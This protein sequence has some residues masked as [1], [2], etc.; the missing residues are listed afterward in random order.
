[1]LTSVTLTQN[2]LT[3]IADYV[4]V[5]PLKLLDWVSKT[6]PQKT[7]QF[8]LSQNPAAICFILD[9]SRRIQLEL[10]TNK[11]PAAIHIWTNL[12]PDLLNWHYL[13]KSQ[14]DIDLLEKNPN[15]IE[16]K[17]LSLNPAA[18]HLL[19]S[20]SDRINWDN[21]S[22]N[23]AAIHLLEA[24]PDC[25]NWANLSKN[26]A[27]IH[28]IEA[29]LDRINWDNLSKNTAAIHLLE[30]NPDCI[31]WD[32]LSKNP[33]AVHL[34]EANLDCINWNNL[35]QNP[36]AIH[37]LES[38][39]DKINWYYLLNNPSILEVDSAEYIADML[40]FVTSI[41]RHKCACRYL[42]YSQWPKLCRTERCGGRPI[43][44]NHSHN[45]SRGCL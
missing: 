38:N 26:I 7:W 21:L 35:S 10:I 22:K 3:V 44:S 16:W 42:Q 45:C 32:N 13:S 39:P 19:E 37:L 31:N 40:E 17:E 34:L 25:I 15:K 24:N 43:Y 33:A 2:A 11:H 36:A 14:H 28:L 41:I 18:I 8:G 27:A 4:V 1:M 12:F 23:I 30:A 29:N 5:P 20:N 6:F 9:D